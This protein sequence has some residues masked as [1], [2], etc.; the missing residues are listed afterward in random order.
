MQQALLKNLTTAQILKNLPTDYTQQNSPG[1]FDNRSVAQEFP[2]V[3]WNPKS[4]CRVQ[5]YT[6]LDPIMIQLKTVRIPMPCFSKTRFNIYLRM[7]IPRSL[8]FLIF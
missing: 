6:P 7:K 8:F 3:V 5:T 1:E 4:H 2:C